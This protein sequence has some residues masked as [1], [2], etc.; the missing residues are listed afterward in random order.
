M[1]MKNLFAV[2]LTVFLLAGLF[3]GCSAENPTA[4]DN[5]ASYDSMVPTQAGYDG[6]YD[7]T[8]SAVESSTTSAAAQ[9]R[10]LIKT[11][12]MRAETKELDALLSWLDS[13]V[14]ALGGYVEQRDIYNGSTYSTSR[15]R[16]ADLTIRIPADQADAFVEEVG[17]YSNIISTNESVE[18]V[19]L[20]YVATESRMKALQAEEERL[21]EL[22]A[23]AE[24]MSDL[25]QIEERLTDVR[26]ELESVTSQLRTYDNLVRYAT[27]SLYVSE[28]KELTEPEPV[29][30]WE[31]ISTGFAQSLKNLGNTL[32]ELG[33]FLIVNI[34]Y[35]LVLGV[36]ALVVLLI[37]RKAS[38]KDRKITNNQAQKDEKTE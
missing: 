26:Y 33:V 8:E 23:Q 18:D 36:I 31:R 27:V 16:S 29:T 15:S 1:K 35:I 28:V 6:I 17:D 21:L 7:R 20:T 32:L 24:D 30:L 3:A 12:N 25:L 34:P 37:C 2:L 11:V 38:P 14:A 22:M 4:Y 19:T 13:K 10:K 9:N 5:G